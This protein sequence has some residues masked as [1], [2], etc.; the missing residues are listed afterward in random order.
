MKC[1]KCG[2]LN[3]KTASR[4]DCGYDFATKKVKETYLPVQAINKAK[5]QRQGR[6][7]FYSTLFLVL[8]GLLCIGI[9]QGSGL[10]GLVT[11]G[12]VSLLAGT[13]ARLFW[14]ATKVNN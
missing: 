12:W 10:P 5:Q 13:L 3:H 1:P 8:G 11:L 7:L 6:I 2:L 4:C 14:W 9:G